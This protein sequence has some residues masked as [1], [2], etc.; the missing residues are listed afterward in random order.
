MGILEI[1]NGDP[2]RTMRLVLAEVLKK[3]ENSCRLVTKGYIIFAQTEID[4]G[5][6]LGKKRER[7]I[8]FG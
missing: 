6:I 7:L 4:K 1:P 2:P 3:T 5:K 8:I